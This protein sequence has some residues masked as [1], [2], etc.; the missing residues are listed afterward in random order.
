MQRKVASRLGIDGMLIMGALHHVWSVQLAI[1]PAEP[2]WVLSVVGHAARHQT[3]GRAC[4]A[5]SE[6]QDACARGDRAPLCDRRLEAIASNKR[7]VS[8]LRSSELLGC[9]CAHL[10]SAVWLAKKALSY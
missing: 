9:S 4:R 3:V 7:L 10:A 8:T 1:E 6:A 2:G 5:R